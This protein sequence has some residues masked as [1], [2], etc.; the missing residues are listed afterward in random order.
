[1]SNGY[2]IIQITSIE[3]CAEWINGFD[4]QYPMSDS[5]KH[6]DKHSYTEN[7]VT[8]YLKDLTLEQKHELASMIEKDYKAEYFELN[9]LPALK[10]ESTHSNVFKAA[11]Y[12]YKK[13]IYASFSEALRA[14]WRRCKVIAKLA[15]GQLEFTFRKGTGEIRKAIGTLKVDSQPRKSNKAFTPDVIAYFD[16]EVNDWRRFRIERLIAA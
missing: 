5:S 9:D 2:T 10:K 6:W 13:G 7:H 14:A 1:M 11:W 3:T 4:T 16:I 12:F 15:S 8:N